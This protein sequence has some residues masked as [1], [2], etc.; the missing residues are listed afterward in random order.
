MMTWRNN[1]LFCSFGEEGF[2]FSALDAE[3]S[4]KVRPATL[5]SA[6]SAENTG[7]LI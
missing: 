5:D 4:A 1:V 2:L 6:S 7:V 3:P